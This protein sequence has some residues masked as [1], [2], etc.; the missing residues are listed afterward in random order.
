MSYKVEYEIIFHYNKDYDPSSPSTMM[1][2]AD[3]YEII[4]HYNKDYD[5]LL[6]AVKRLFSLV[7]DH[8]PLQ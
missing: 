3:R 6:L 4:F 7:R 1:P 5:I 2:E 8:L